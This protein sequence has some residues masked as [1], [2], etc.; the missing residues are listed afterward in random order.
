MQRNRQIWGLVFLSPW[1]FGFLAFYLFPMVASLVLSFTNYNLNEPTQIDWIGMANYERM[2][3]GGDPLVGVSLTATFRF[4]L[5]ALPLALILPVLLAALLNSEYL[6]G[7]RF[8]RTLFYMPYMVPI[9]SAVYIWQGMLNSETGWINRFL[10]EIGIAGPNWL[11]DTTWIYPAL[12]IIGL[13]GLGNAFLITL[14]SMQGVP[15]ELYEAARVDGAGPL[16]RFRHIT[17]P[18]IS[19]VIFYNLILSVVGLFRY[20]EIPYILSQG[21]GRPGQ[22][23]MFLNI[24]LYKNA[25]VFKEMGYGSALAW[26]LFI[27]AFIATALIFVTARYWVYYAAGDQD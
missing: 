26:L 2:L 19:P 10:G 25:F 1:I 20:F 11:N 14:A 24:H 5:I 15:T 17:L 9:I 8:F 13:W 22:S 12:N 23:T 27:L 6:A 21:T 4:A 16:R 7:K 18:M 3:T